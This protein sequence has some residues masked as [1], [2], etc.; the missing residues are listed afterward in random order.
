MYVLYRLFLVCNAGHTVH[1]LLK[2]FVVYLFTNCLNEVALPIRGI[3]GIFIVYAL[4][5]NI[6]MP[7]Y[8]NG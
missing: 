5:G 2:A 1:P 4:D 3:P 7:V 8:L 6:P